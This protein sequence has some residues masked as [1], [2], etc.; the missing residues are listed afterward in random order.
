VQLGGGRNSSDDVILTWV[1]RERIGGEWLDYA[2][3]AQED[4]PI[5]WALSVWSSNS[6]ATL[7]RAVT[8]Y[9]Y[10]GD[11]TTYTY[12]AAL[13]TTDFGSAQATLYWSVKVAGPSGF[14]TDARGTT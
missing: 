1:R 11:A 8:I 9:T 12:T 5:E 6:Y 13:Q 3:V 14:G 10:P 2:D 4:V 7:K